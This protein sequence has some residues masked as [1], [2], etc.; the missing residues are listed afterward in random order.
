MGGITA[1]AELLVER[2]GLN[3]TGGRDV[4]FLRSALSSAIVDCI[5]FGKSSSRWPCAQSFVELSEACAACAAVKRRELRVDGNPADVSLPFELKEA[6][7]RRCCVLDDCDFVASLCL[8]A[9]VGES[10]DAGRFA[11]EVEGVT[12]VDVAGV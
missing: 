7:A 4:D 11:A 8:A 6:G 2:G 9:V 10:N 1:L 3:E 5:A 12:C